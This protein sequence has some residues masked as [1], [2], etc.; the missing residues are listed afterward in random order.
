[1]SP[2]DVLTDRMADLI[3]ADEPFTADDL[4]QNGALCVDANHQ[5]NGAQNSVGA[6]FRYHS[7]HGHITLTGQVRKSASVH[8]RGGLQQVW[9]PTIGGYWWAVQH[10]TTLDGL[11]PDDPGGRL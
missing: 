11:S 1:M 3:L 2:T 5:P 7:Q 6:L 9:A 10:Q 8:R 4:T